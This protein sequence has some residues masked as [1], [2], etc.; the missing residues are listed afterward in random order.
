[1]STSPRLAGTSTRMIGGRLTLPSARR[2]NP[3]ATAAIASSF[4]ATARRISPS[5][6][7]VTCMSGHSRGQLLPSDGSTYHPFIDAARFVREGDMKIDRFD[8]ERTQCLYEHEV[9]FN[10]S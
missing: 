7:I 5:V 2:P 4:I 9:E 1:M 6:R 8:M 10:L 3:R